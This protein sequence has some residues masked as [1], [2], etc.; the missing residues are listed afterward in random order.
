MTGTQAHIDELAKII[1]DYHHQESLAR[2]T[3]SAGNSDL[4]AAQ[5]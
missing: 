5:L 3:A 1:W 4:A 2:P